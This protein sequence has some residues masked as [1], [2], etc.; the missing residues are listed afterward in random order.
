MRVLVVGV[1]AI[2]IGTLAF[3]GLLTI[4]RELFCERILEAPS[5]TDKEAMTENRP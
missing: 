1:L 4:V 3:I 5:L 2:G